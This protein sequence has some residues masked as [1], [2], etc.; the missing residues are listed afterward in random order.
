MS[1]STSSSAVFARL[2]RVLNTDTQTTLRATSVAIGRICVC[3]QAM[4][5]K[6]EETSTVLRK[7]DG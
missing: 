1:E 3:M 7:D 6:I 5:L 4:R 2:T